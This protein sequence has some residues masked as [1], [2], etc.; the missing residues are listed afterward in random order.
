MYKVLHILWGG[1]M[2]IA[3]Q[4]VKELVSDK[5]NP[6]LQ[7]HI[8]LVTQEGGVLNNSTVVGTPLMSAN[9][10]KLNQINY[11]AE[12]I[13][14]AILEWGIDLVHCHSTNVFV[15]NQLRLIEGC[16]IMMTDHGD[17]EK[18]KDNEFII[19]SLWQMHGQYLDKIILPSSDICRQF[20]K[21]YPGLSSQATYLKSPCLEQASDGMRRS[22]SEDKIIGFIDDLE[23]DTGADKFICMAAMIHAS[24]P[25]VKFHIYGSGSLEQHLKQLAN[26]LNLSSVISFNG[27]GLDESLAIQQIDLLM[28][29]NKERPALQKLI[30]S[31]VNGTPVIAPKDMGVNDYIISGTNG[32]LVNN[33]DL[34]GYAEKAT[35]LLQNENQWA[36][37]SEE[38]MKFVD[39][40]LS[41]SK[42]IKDLKLIYKS[43]LTANLELEDYS[44]SV[45]EQVDLD[46]SSSKFTLLEKYIS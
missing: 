22:L 39:K 30:N 42:H 35:L 18:V 10:S 5:S 20:N 4:Y 32:Y 14:T 6:L 26:H 24:S 12:R 40:E 2:G 28:I 36:N 19:D 3:Q 27:D 21:N 38:A 45:K 33:D 34:P 23:P 13:N 15:M 7:H 37:Y 29:L 8:F 1:E 17:I 41:V 31:M 11:C 9:C 16:K 44:I 46:L 25:K 43:V